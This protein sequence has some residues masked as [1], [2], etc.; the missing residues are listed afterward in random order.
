MDYKLQ[1]HSQQSEH[2]QMADAM[3]NELLSKCTLDEQN[4]AVYTI[5]QRIREARINRLHDL[6]INIEIIQKSIESI[7]LQFLEQTK[8]VKY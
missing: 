3:A 4:E 6:Q 7:P 8:Q 2:L 1:G 5:L